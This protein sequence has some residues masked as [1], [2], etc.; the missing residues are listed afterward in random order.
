MTGKYRISMAPLL[1]NGMPRVWE[2]ERRMAK[3]WHLF[4]E[5]CRSLAA[6]GLDYAVTFALTG[7][8]PH[9]LIT[10][11]GTAMPK[12]KP[13]SRVRCVA[14]IPPV[15]SQQCAIHA[16]EAEWFLPENRERRNASTTHWRTRAGRY[17]E[18]N[19]M[20]EEELRADLAYWRELEVISG[21]R[22]HFKPGRTDE[23]AYLDDEVAA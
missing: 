1:A 7:S 16:Q 23:T 2:S 13:A 3:R 10:A 4:V 20:A 17:A 18:L 21:Q 9:I 5:T 19:A 14:L 22:Q 8:D 15:K 11:S 6:D 12:R